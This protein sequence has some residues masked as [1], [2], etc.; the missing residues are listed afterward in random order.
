MSTT[1]RIHGGDRKCVKIVAEKL[2]ENALL[3][4]R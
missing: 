3:K 1:R 2:E 4:T